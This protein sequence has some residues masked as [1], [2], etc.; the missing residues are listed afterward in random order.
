MFN[1]VLLLVAVDGNVT[2][3]I[4]N[5]RLPEA[6]CVM[7]ATSEEARLRADP[8]YLF[9]EARCIPLFKPA[10]PSAPVKPLRDS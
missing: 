2:G 6:R 10:E 8:A 5:A 4:G 7:M 3:A 1:L 9:V